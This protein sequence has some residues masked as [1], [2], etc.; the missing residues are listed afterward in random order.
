[1][2]P[3]PIVRPA[4]RPLMSSAAALGALGL[5]LA[6]CA[7]GGE[8]DD[9]ESETITLAASYPLT[10]ESAAYGIS[11]QKGLLL[12]V[13]EINAQ[14]GIDGKQVVVK[15]FDDKCDATE[16]ANVGNQIISDTSIEM[17]VGTVCSGATNAMYPITAAADIPL[18]SATASNPALAENGWDLFTRVIPTDTYQSVLL[19]KLAGSLGYERIA[20]VA[21]NDDYGQQIVS[22]LQDHAEQYGVEIVA[23][24]RYTT[25]QISDFTPILTNL[26]AADPDVI[27]LGGYYGEMGP[28]VSQS[29]T[30]F[31]SDGI[32]F[33]GG[34]QAQTQ[35]FLALAGDAADD[36]VTIAQL[37]DVSSTSPEN[38]EFVEKFEAEYGELPDF[39]A[40]YG[41]DNIWIL[42]E[43][44][45][46]NGG[47]L[48]GITDAI[49]GVTTT[50]ATGTVEF[51]EN[52]NNV[53]EVGV[54]IR[55]VDGEF[56]FD[57]EATDAM[58]AYT[59]R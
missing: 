41:W 51:A 23:E 5:L 52:G 29:P 47:D 56:V 8:A 19:D 35:E 27:V 49:K 17:V 33:I 28:L 26:R 55:I 13:D 34:S 59:A 43:A 25:G 57:A 24:E 2:A 38:T 53:A 36:T 40:A 50:G 16:G 54:V 48:D 20:V 32:P 30:V 12:A 37:Y 1:M 21:S 18:F 10:G 9:S 39:Q 58:V 4:R 3:T 45:E 6:G 44:V 42:K 7:S 31:G 15:E 14:G 22:S 11:T 46:A